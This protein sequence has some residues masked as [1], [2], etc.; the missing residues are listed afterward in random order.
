MKLC[1]RGHDYKYAVEQI[2]LAMFPGELPD[3]SRDGAGGGL[4]ACVR[5]GY[6]AVY[7][8]A[9][10]SITG[11]GDVGRGYARVRR[12]ALTDALER[13]RLLQS[14]VKRAFYKAA[15]AVSGTRPVWGS[16]TGIRPAGVAAGLIKRG[17]TERGAVRALRRTYH[18][19]PERAALC[20]DAARQAAEVESGLPDRAAM[21]Y[22]GIPFCPS[23]CAYCSFVSHSVEKSGALIAPFLGA[24]RA[25]LGAV[26]GLARSLGLSIFAVYVGGGTPTILT[27][28]QLDG[29]LGDVSALFSL[30]DAREFTVEAGRPDTITREK[31]NVMRS[32]GVTRISVN[33]QSMSDAVLDAIGRRHTAR[34]AVRAVE[35]ARTAGFD[36]VNMDVIAGLPSDTASGF[37][38]TM[39]SVLALRPENVTVHTL[40]LKKGSRITLDSVPVPDGGAVSVM[41]ECAASRLR[42]AGYFPYYLYRQKFTSG[43]FENVGWSLPGHAGVYN[44]CMMEELRTVLACGGGGVTKLV[45]RASGRIKRVFNPKYPYEYVERIESIIGRKTEIEVF[46]RGI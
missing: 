31:L 14:A 15:V 41:L 32:R 34:D 29:L 39:D 1:L 3:Y 36:D 27:A 13:D 22:V 5:L 19:A 25:E 28:S 21:L 20:V 44:V 42:A 40:S 12:A 24:L 46:F 10:V 35:D 17:A 33:P 23:R 38:A 16:V 8:T 6:G 26:A 4:R 30:A 43:G 7:A 37:A 2:M 18:V 9:S 11:G 45:D